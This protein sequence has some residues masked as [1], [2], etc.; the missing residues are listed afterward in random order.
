MRPSIEV[1]DTDPDSSRREEFEDV[2]SS[3]D[4][5]HGLDIICGISDFIVRHKPGEG[6]EI[7][8]PIRGA[9][10]IFYR[11]K[12]G[13]GTSAGMR[14]PCQGSISSDALILEPFNLISR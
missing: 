11:V 6:A 3:E 1:A 13:D 5:I 10:N 4:S 8:A 7:Q 14:V 12:Y 2:E 9:Y